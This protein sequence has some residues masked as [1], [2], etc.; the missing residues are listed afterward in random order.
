MQN[1]ST[2]VGVAV[3]ITAIAILLILLLGYAFKAVLLIIAASL[4]ASFFFGIAKWLSKHTPLSFP[5]SMG[6]TLVGIL[7]IVVA[8]NW[9]VAAQV[10]SQIGELQ[11][12]LPQAIEE[13]RNQLSQTS[14]GSNISQRIPENSEEVVSKIQSQGSKLFQGTFGFLSGVFGILADIYIV[15]LLAL[16]FLANPSLYKEGIKLL[17]P[18][19]HR[20]RA[21]E[22]L[23]SLGETLSRWTVGKLLSMAI[24]AVMTTIG[25]LIINVPMAWAL[26]V[27]TG[28]LAFVPNFGPLISYVIGASFALLEGPQTA[29]IALA[30]YIGVQII[31]SNLLTPLIQKRM[32]QLPPAMVFIAQVVM[33][34]LFGGWGIVLAVPLAVIVMVLVK[35]IYIGDILQDKAN[36]KVLDQ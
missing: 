21:Q 34:I 24:V 32:V 23:N 27:I 8:L 6:A 20:D 15:L 13:V 25:L 33:G 7:L 1:Y 9:L 11:Q 2:K 3:G 28:I 4:L 19:P 26:G 14:W 22:I 36:A 12:K 35:K 17:V 18:P 16:Y 29:L 31:E 30:I 5:W 10:S